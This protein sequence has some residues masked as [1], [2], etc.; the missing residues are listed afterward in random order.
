MRR[1]KSIRDDVSSDRVYVYDAHVKFIYFSVDC[2]VIKLSDRCRND[3]D[4]ADNILLL[5]ITYQMELWKKKV[6][7]DSVF[8]KIC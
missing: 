6:I 8:I 3:P 1:F 4:E 5:S 2:R 7:T